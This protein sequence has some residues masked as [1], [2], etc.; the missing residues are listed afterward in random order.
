MILGRSVGL[1]TTLN[2]HYRLTVRN[3]IP[4][5]RAQGPRDRNSHRPLAVSISYRAI[6]DAV[7]TPR[8]DVDYSISPSPRPSV[9]TACARTQVLWSR[10]PCTSLCG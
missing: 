3:L 4:I 10:Y 2:R 1:H 7:K 9:R 5:A 8:S 6:Y